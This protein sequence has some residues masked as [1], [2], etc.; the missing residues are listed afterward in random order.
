MLYILQTEPE[1]EP[2]VV[3]DIVVWGYII[4]SL[5][6][7]FLLYK[8]SELNKIERYVLVLFIHGY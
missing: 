2:P 3:F 4:T 1:E 6:L 8:E 7:A 5:P